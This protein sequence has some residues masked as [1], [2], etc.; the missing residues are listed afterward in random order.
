[1]HDDIPYIRAGSQKS[2]AHEDSEA[3]VI[4]NIFKDMKCVPADKVR[5]AFAAEAV[6]G[7]V[8]EEETESAR[9]A[10]APEDPEPHEVPGEEAPLE[11]EGS[12]PETLGGGIGE[13]PE[14]DDEHEMEVEGEGAPVRK[15]KVGTL[16]A[17]A[18]SLCTFVNSSLSRSLS[19]GMQSCQDETLQ[20]ATWCIQT[21]T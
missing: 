14:L 7:D 13:L 16:K 11:E 19:R 10:D 5:V 9:V 18:K 15:A 2:C 8:A 3:T 6:P 12:P 20:D 1:M 17:E 21:R 4:R